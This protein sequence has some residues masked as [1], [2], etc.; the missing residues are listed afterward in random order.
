MSSDKPVPLVGGSGNTAEHWTLNLTKGR[1]SSAPG[2]PPAAGPG[3]YAG[4]SAWRCSPP[5]LQYSAAD[6]WLLPPSSRA[7]RSRV[8][9]RLAFVSRLRPGARVAPPAYVVLTSAALEADIDLAGGCACARR[10]SFRGAPIELA[11][12]SAVSWFQLLSGRA[13]GNRLHPGLVG[14]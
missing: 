12:R 7:A 10:Q 13:I 9:T 3:W 4:V 1:S 5:R 8:V 6:S 2:D 14:C 11:H